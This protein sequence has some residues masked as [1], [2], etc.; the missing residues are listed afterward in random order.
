MNVMVAMMS[1]PPERA[2]LCAGLCEE[3]QQELEDAA[4]LVGAMRKVTVIPARDAEHPREIQHCAADGCSGRDASPDSPERKQMDR[5]EGN[6]AEPFDLGWLSGLRTRVGGGGFV[7]DAD[8]PV[9]VRRSA[10]A[11]SCS[12]P[13]TFRVRVR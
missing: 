5:N 10:K 13:G 4:G 12:S 3:C 6:A 2:L 11:Q 1:G 8:G 7:H 9:A